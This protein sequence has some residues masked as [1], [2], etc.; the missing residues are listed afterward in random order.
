[1][2]GANIGAMI[3]TAGDLLA[4]TTGIGILGFRIWVVSF[5]NEAPQA[6]SNSVRPLWWLLG[7]CIVVL[8]LSSLG[9]LIR[10]GMEMS[11][12]PLTEIALVM[13]AVLSKTHFGRVWLFRPVALLVLWL[14][15]RARPHFDSPFVSALML[16]AAGLIAASRSLSGHA[17]DWGDITLHEVMDWAHLLAASVWGGS[18]VGLTVTGFRTLTEGAGARRARIATMAQRWSTLAGVALAV[19]VLTGI[20]N[21]WLQ[22]QR[23]EA[24]WQTAYGRTLSIKLSLVLVIVAL[25]ATNRY[26]GLP[27]LRAWADRLANATESSPLEQFVRRASVEGILIIGALLCVAVLLTEMP[28]RHQRPVRSSQH[29]HASGLAP[30][31]VNASLQPHALLSSMT[32]D[33]HR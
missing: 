19:V 33:M 1:M 12:R 25:G 31:A 24:L 32:P 6:S 22:L 23:F 21:A 14:G 17:A 5:K 28:A 9:E 30:E 2:T 26:F 10:R 8:T 3:I 27:S 4:L 13:P 15:W 7:A 29:I 20:Y 16:V 11:G 18:L